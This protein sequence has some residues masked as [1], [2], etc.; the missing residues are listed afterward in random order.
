MS[1]SSEFIV[2]IVFLTWCEKNC[3]IVLKPQKVDVN[4]FDNIKQ[5]E[6]K[7]ILEN[8]LIQEYINTS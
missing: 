8:I 3:A 4:N 6:K 7:I 5:S 2:W 1:S